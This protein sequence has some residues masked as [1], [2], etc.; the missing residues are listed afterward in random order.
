MATIVDRFVI[1]H[2]T[3]TKANQVE[4]F[5]YKKYTELTFGRAATN[6]CPL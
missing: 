5:D 6:L 2:L 1:R 4:E 3:G